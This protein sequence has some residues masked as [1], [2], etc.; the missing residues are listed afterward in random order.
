MKTIEDV[1]QKK[2][3]GSVLIV[4]PRSVEKLAESANNIRK[5]AKASGH[6][7]KHYLDIAGFF[8]RLSGKLPDSFQFHVAEARDFP[9]H[10]YE[11]LTFPDGQILIHENV[12]DGAHE[13]KGRDR[14]TMTHELQHWVLH[15][16]EFA[17]ARSS[18]NMKVFKDPEW[19]ANT[20][21]SLTLMSLK[22]VEKFSGDVEQLAD[23][24]G[25]SVPA[26]EARM[27][28]HSKHG[29]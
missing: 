25:V 16:N 15:R 7:D 18:T 4:A 9:D 5:L 8:E 13:G 2:N 28:I 19:Q 1:A 20:G 27:R 22:S 11:G 17:W 26:A 6:L 10:T 29:F 23:A 3:S 12:Y 24:C 21:A 14:F